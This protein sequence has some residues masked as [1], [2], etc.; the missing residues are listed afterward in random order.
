MQEVSHHVCKATY[1]YALE[2]QQSNEVFGIVWY[3]RESSDVI[4]CFIPATGGINDWRAEADRFLRAIHVSLNV[5]LELD[6]IIAIHLRLVNG[7]VD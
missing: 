5:T 4:G 2:C 7:I 1:E 3:G 6:S